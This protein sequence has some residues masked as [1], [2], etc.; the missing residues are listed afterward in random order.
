MTFMALF[1][2]FQNISTASFFLIK[3]SSSKSLYDNSYFG[4][5]RIQLYCMIHENLSIKA[6]RKRRA[7]RFICVYGQQTMHIIMNV[8][9]PGD[10]FII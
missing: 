2:D 4:Y 1:V 5:G 8:K 3:K 6:L 9:L 7:Y 10:A